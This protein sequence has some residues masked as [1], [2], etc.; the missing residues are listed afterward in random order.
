MSAALPEPTGALMSVRSLP[1]AQRY[2][3]RWVVGAGPRARSFC[4]ED[5]GPGSDF[6]T[7][8]RAETLPEIARA[9]SSNKWK[10]QEENHRQ[11]TLPPVAV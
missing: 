4:H 3:V 1:L 9:K 11:L 7:T 6:G 2:T 5:M 8:R 10:G